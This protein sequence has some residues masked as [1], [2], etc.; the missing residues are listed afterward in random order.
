M[1][2]PFQIS[3]LETL[4]PPPPDSMRVL[5]HPPTPI[6]TPWH[7]PTLGHRTPTGPRVFPSLMSNEAILCHIGG[8]SHGSLHVYFLVGGPGPR[9][10]GRSGCLTLL[11]PPWSCKP[12]QLL[13]S[14]LQFLHRGPH[15]LHLPLYLSGSGR[16]SQ[17]TALSGSLQQALPGIYNT[18]Q[19]WWLYMGWIPRCIVQM[20]G[21]VSCAFSWAS[22]LLFDL[23]NFAA[24]VS[25]C[26]SLLYFILFYFILFY[27][28]IPS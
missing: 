21:S 24:Y 15:A 27:F 8:Q 10:S 4:Y 5:P 13:Q 16:A 18:V 26:F 9:S 1:F 2:S 11:L 17:E 14:L 22:F 19:V 7:S 3:P 20:S 23:S 28:I 25:L 12:P 6:F